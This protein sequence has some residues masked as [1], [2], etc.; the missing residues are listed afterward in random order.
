M[1][2]GVCRL[3]EAPSA[4]SEIIPSE[5]EI[6]GAIVVPAAE[7]DAQHRVDELFCCWPEFREGWGV[8]GEEHFAFDAVGG[9]D[10]GVEEF[11]D[12]LDCEKM[13]QGEVEEDFLQE[14]GD[15]EDF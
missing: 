11:G 14:F 9:G 6:G 13:L 12:S 10:C 3:Q 5:Y 4:G 2:A 1:R 7:V 8:V 15:G